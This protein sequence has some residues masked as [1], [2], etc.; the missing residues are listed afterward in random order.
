MSLFI[1]VLKRKLR[2][3]DGGVLRIPGPSAPSSTSSTSKVTYDKDTTAARK[4]VFG[5]TNDFLDKYSETSDQQKWLNN[6]YETTINNRDGQI[7]DQFKDSSGLSDQILNGDFNTDLA[8]IDE[9]ADPT[10]TKYADAKTESAGAAQG[11]GYNDAVLTQSD[12]YQAATAGEIDPYQAALTQLSPDYQ[13]STASLSDLSQA[14]KDLG[15]VDPTQSLQQLLSGKIDNPYLSSMH[16]A[17]VNDSMRGY[18]DAVQKLNQ[19]TM[20]GI[21]N[22]AFAAGQYGGSRQGVA[23]GLAMQQLERNARDLGIEAM[24]SG[25]QLYGN[26]YSQA[27]QNMMGTANNLNSLAA[28]NSQF[29]TGQLTQNSQFNANNQLQNQQFNASQGNN[30]AQ[31]NAGNQL[32]NQQFDTSQFNNMAQYNAGNQLNNQQFNA[33]AANSLNLA[34]SAGQAGASQFSAG[35]AN[36]MN[37]FNA[38]AA[39]QANQFNASNSLNN[40]QF[41]S[42]NLM[43]NNQFNANLGLQNNT[44]QMGQ[45]GQNLQNALTGINTGQTALTNLYAGQD[46]SYAKS[47][48]LI[49]YEPNRALDMIDIAKGAATMSP[50]GST[51]T[52]MGGGNPLGQLIGQ[53]GG[54]FLT[55]GALSNMVN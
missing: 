21:N 40:N 39:N 43:G 6:W 15:A 44:Q 16:Q 29:N 20:P 24:D 17:Y 19:E 48:T 1:G 12:P 8:P 18:G 30:M 32:N 11:A 53:A 50:S 28:Q 9:T 46:S 2:C 51:T 49:N 55:A 10:K 38:G 36:Q 54:S 22:D 37:Q 41:N 45:T 3:A 31:Y 13:G 14:R 52:T 47:N 5:M 27:Q 7:D 25:N 4:E 35:E 33:G 26:A 34:N 23:Q 42:T